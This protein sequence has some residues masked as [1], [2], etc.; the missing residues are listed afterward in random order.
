MA[1]AL[2]VII[3]GNVI[4]HNFSQDHKKNSQYGNQLAKNL[5]KRLNSAVIW[6]EYA[7]AEKNLFIKEKLMR[8]LLASEPNVLSVFAGKITLAQ[9]GQL[10]STWQN[11]VIVRKNAVA[12]DAAIP[13]SEILSRMRQKDPINALKITEDKLELW[14]LRSADKQSVEAVVI[15]F[16]T[17]ILNLPA[18]IVGRRWEI[19][20]NNATFKITAG[21]KIQAMMAGAEDSESFSNEAKIQQIELSLGMT[22]AEKILLKEYSARQT[23]SPLILGPVVWGILGMAY[24]LIAWIFL[25]NYISRPM[26]EL[27]R[28]SAE[29]AKGNLHIKSEHQKL[30]DFELV[31]QNLTGSAEVFISIFRNIHDKIDRLITVSKQIRLSS[32][33]LSQSTTTQASSLEETSASLEEMSAQI[34]HNSDNAKNTGELAAQTSQEAEEGAFAVAETVSAMKQ[35]L[36]KIGVIE[37]IASQT[38][39]LALNATIEAARAGENGRGFAVVASEVGKLAETSQNAARDIRSLA[40]ESAQISQKAGQMLQVMMPNVRK[41]TGLVEEIAASSESQ[42]IA[43]QQIS[44]A[45]RQLDEMSQNNAGLAQELADTSVELQKYASELQIEIEKFGMQAP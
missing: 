19:S 15:A 45:V 12:A 41:T 18:D 21:G 22:P 43:A 5:E 3:A 23:V 35:I 24:I 36:E 1:T 2:V 29:F 31:C 44:R 8:G 13:V 9:P 11:P 20:Q 33:N 42:N 34:Y 26:S 6:S 40:S 17:E 37:E 25:R 39:L 16:S 30:A 27:I 7:Q 10:Q 32:Q 4:I 14:V 38:N 28:I